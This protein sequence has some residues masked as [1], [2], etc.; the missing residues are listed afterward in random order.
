MKNTLKMLAWLSG[1]I[2]II[3]MII[4][5]IAVAAG[6]ILWNHMWSNYFY[7]A[8]NFLLLGIFLLL[9]ALSTEHTDKKG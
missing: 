3:L 5:I 7:P 9:G 6:G 4:G 8:Y 1:A 2:G